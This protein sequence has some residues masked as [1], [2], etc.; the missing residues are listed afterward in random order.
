MTTKDIFDSL[1]YQE[2]GNH[3]SKMKVQPAYFINENKGGEEDIKKAI[4]YLKMILDR[5]YS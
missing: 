1:K 5:D 3:Y 2:G 4:H